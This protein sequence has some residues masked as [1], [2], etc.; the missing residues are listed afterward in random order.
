MATVWNIIAPYSTP[1]TKNEYTE[2]EPKNYE[3][4][5]FHFRR[6]HVFISTG[7]IYWL[8][9]F[10]RTVK[11]SSPS[12]LTEYFLYLDRFWYLYSKQAYDVRLN[13]W[14]NKEVYV[15]IC[16][17]TSNFD[18]SSTLIRYIIESHFVAHASKLKTH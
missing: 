4:T 3:V 13:Y 11:N 15:F 17:S 5:I 8:W 7:C 16:E 18:K 10:F 2:Y 9:I 1:T 12:H 6:T 14:H